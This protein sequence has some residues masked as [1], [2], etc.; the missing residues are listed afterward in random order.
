MLAAMGEVGHALG[1]VGDLIADLPPGVGRAAA[2]VQ[3][4]ELEDD[5]LE[6]G[7]RSLRR[8]LADA[9]EDH[10]LRGQVL[11][12]LGWLQGVFRGDLPG[13]IERAREGLPARRSHRRRGAPALCGAR[14]FTMEVLHG[15]PRVDLG[16][17]AIELEQELGRPLLWGG[18]RVLMA[19]Q[20]LW[21]GE[22]T[23][24]RDLFESANRQGASAGNERWL[25]YGLYNLAAVECAAGA[26]MRADELVQQ[27]MQTARDCEDAHVESWT[28]LRR[29]MVSAW[30]GRADEAR[31]A[32]EQRLAEAESR[33]E[34]PGVARIRTV[35]GILALSE[36]DATEAVTQLRDAAAV[37]AETGYANPGAIPR[38]TRS[39]RWRVPVTPTRPASCSSGWPASRRRSTTTWSGRCTTG[40]KASYCW[41]TALPGP[42]S[43]R[44]PSQS[45]AST[46]SG[47]GPTLL[48]PSSSSA[49]RGSARV[50]GRG[51]P[52]RWPTLGRGSP[53]WV[54][55]CGRPAR[56]PSWSEW[57]PGVPPGSSRRPSAASPTWSRRGTATARSPRRCTS[58]RRRSRHT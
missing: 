30:L 52:R 55:C 7:E 46:G 34:R 16:T 6:A 49:G 23:R 1:E 31:A 54:P 20:L 57:P 40:P 9:G 5:D 58:A 15:T 38:R 45:R 43:G 19:E 3:R 25:A 41:R 10:R 26:L 51:R 17:E 56:S 2:L 53:T 44:W 39:R 48:A 11:D 12:Q 4:A 21:S 22:L 29:A 24:A 32:A 18:P 42:R 27:A 14:A 50:A 33:G 47:T 36:D 35:L 28:R 8:A 37:M 13:G